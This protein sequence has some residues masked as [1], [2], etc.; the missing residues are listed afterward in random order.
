[1]MV[2]RAAVTG[3]AGTLAG[4]LMASLTG[5]LLSAFLF[6]IDPFDPLTYL[7]VAGLLG[8]GFLPARKIAAL[9]P[10]EVLRA[11]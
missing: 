1:M 5:R 9:D 7:V 8:A 3:V 6:G 4:L 11:E 2:R 10:A